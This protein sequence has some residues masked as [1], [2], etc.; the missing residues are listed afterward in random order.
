MESR[1]LRASATASDDLDA[2][3]DLTLAWRVYDLQGN[4]VLQGGNEPVYNITDLSA[5]YYIVEVTA[6]DSMG[7]SS[8]ASVDIEYTQLDTDG[9][10]TS[11]CSSDTWFDGSTGK[12]W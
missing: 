2:T 8:S 3:S 12:S 9:D 4:T 10:W 6:T 5:G 7:L 11:T 1:S